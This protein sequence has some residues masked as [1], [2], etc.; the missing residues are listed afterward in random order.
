MSTEYVQ[1]VSEADFD[2]TVIAKSREVPVVVDFWA[3]WCGPC[4]TLGPLLEK[5]AAEG[6][7]VFI[8]AKLNVD[9]NPMLATQ[10]NVRGIP[11]V[12]AFRDGVVVADFVGAIPEPKV[13]DFINKL[14]PTE[15][16]R[17]LSEAHSLLAIRHWAEA[18][19]AFRR[20]LDGLA[21]NAAAALGLVKSLLAQGQ[22]CE[23]TDL[24]ENFPGGS[25]IATAEKLEPLAN[26]LCEIESP[27]EPLSESDLD[28]LFYQSGRLLA[29]GQ[30]EAGMDG[31]LETL[32][33][34]KKYRK[35][36]P[37]RIILGL[38]EL[39][40][41]DDPRTREYRQELASVLF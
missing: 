16:D 23:A 33:R 37:R 9:D 11:A 19:S 27:D 34:D 3:P 1:E 38:F 6:K 10:Y 12:K 21:D 5:L 2:F 13:R 20:A 26:L 25:E 18:E 14:A 8:L 41:E 24:I 35:G 28:A 15:A 4:R 17:A 30:L 7:G 36:E 39:M 29:R 31:L 32:R 22:G 40:G